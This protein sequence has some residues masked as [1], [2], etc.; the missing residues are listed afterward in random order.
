MLPRYVIQLDITNFDS[1]V[2]LIQKLK[3]LFSFLSIF[4]SVTWVIGNINLNLEK[5]NKTEQLVKSIL[6]KENYNSIKFFMLEK[7]VYFLNFF[8]FSFYEQQNIFNF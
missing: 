4:K 5:F 2:E 6:V 3:Q 8:L 1:N 7:K